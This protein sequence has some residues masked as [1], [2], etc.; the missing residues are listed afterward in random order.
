MNREMDA[1]QADA[2]LCETFFDP[3]WTM[4]SPCELSLRPFSSG[5]LKVHLND[6]VL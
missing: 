2:S 5:V 3:R 1:G 6:K 4:A